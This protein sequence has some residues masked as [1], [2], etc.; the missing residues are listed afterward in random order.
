MKS[1][2]KNTSLMY[3]IES[4]LSFFHHYL[5]VQSEQWNKSLK[6]KVK[7]VNFQIDSF[8][9]FLLT[10]SETILTK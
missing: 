5:Q 1:V 3:I 4:N 9:F 2:T 10:L 8:L 7:K 6:K